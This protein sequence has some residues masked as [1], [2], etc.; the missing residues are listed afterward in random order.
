VNGDQ[1]HF[2]NPVPQMNYSTV[3]S[4]AVKNGVVYACGWY[5]DASS[6]MV[7]CSWAGTT[8]TPLTPPAGGTNPIAS[9]IKLYGGT[10]Y[11]AGAYTNSA[12]KTVPCLW[13]NNV[14]RDLP[15]PAN[16][17]GLATDSTDSNS[18]PIISG[19][20][21]LDGSPNQTPCY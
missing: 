13:T 12:G 15:I 11:V 18:G 17:T 9:T 1:V 5:M 16:A 8:C 19:Y 14:V 21:A 7:A 20:Y 6:V 3:R 10:V 4:I 2:Y